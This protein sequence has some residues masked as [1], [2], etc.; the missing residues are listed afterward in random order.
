MSQNT[1][2]AS[3]HAGSSGHGHH[4]GFAHVTPGSLLLLIGGTLLFLTA[5]T[6][7]VTYVDLG[8]S[9][10]L[11]VAM[12]IATIKAG[13]VCAY[14]MH[15]RWDKPFNAIVFASSLLFVALFIIVTLLD[16]ADYEG[17]IQ[18]MYLQEGQ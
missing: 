13:L 11:I 10:N 18:E 17:D 8:R 14:F 4:E 12:A 7:W 9:G 1:K 15:L 16:K 3:S 2:E 6:V 5:I